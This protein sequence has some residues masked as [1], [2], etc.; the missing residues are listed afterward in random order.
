MANGD[1]PG[2]VGQ[3]IPV[4]EGGQLVQVQEQKAVLD[5]NKASESKASEA[6]GASKASGQ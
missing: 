5:A 6:S 3:N 1:K 2:F 4:A